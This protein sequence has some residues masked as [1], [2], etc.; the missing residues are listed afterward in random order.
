MT[1][2]YRLAVVAMAAM[3]CGGGG[4]QDG[5]DAATTT[6]G[7][8]IPNG[9]DASMPDESATVF[10]PRSLHTYELV[11]ADAD[12][13]WLNNNFLDETYVPARLIVAEQEE[14]R[15]GLRFKGSTGSLADC[16]DD[17][18][19]RACP[20]V[21]LKLKFNEYVKGQRFRGLKRLN[22]HAYRHDATLMRERLAY[23]LFG[24]AGVRAPRA[25]HAR[26]V[27]NGEYLGLFGAVEAVDSRF[28]R[29]RFGDLGGGDGNIYKEVWPV[30][31][32]DEPYLKSLRTNENDMPDVSRMRRFA[33][34]LAD[35]DAETARGL[36]E[37]WF[38]V[39]ELA[40]YVAVDHA[41]VNWDGIT[42]WY[43]YDGVCS[44]HNNYWYQQPDAD[45]LWMIPWDLDFTFAQ[46]DLASFGVPGLFDDP[47]D[48]EPTEIFDDFTARS[49]AC[50]RLLGIIIATL[51]QEIRDEL[52]RFVS[53]HF[54]VAALTERLDR[55]AAQIEQAVRTDPTVNFA[56]YSAAR[57]QLSEHLA[58]LRA[59]ALATADSE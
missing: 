54:Q 14:L 35:V 6:A 3:A 28:S 32:T 27:V 33:Q 25:V 21:S 39:S 4:A 1:R 48:C 55:W 49:A 16:A 19:V 42:A 9:E 34:A 51:G 11:V 59:A 47:E 30:H 20:K 52:R 57:R 2:A 7:D 46:D 58:T 43:C 15:V 50:D 29:S 23:T 26:V 45:R 38:D 10:D 44:N 5:H 13:Q 40:R 22:L 8:A 41:I 24:L 36:L 31:L 56:D 12:W 18:G 37:S 53:D 17:D